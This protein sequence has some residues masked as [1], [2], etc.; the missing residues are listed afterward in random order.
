MVVLVSE[1]AVEVVHG[2]SVH[3]IKQLS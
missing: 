2:S 1:V 3:I